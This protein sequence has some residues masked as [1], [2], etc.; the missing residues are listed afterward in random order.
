MS[1]VGQEPSF[2]MINIREILVRFVLLGVN[3]R[4]SETRSICQKQTFESVKYYLF[5]F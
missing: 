3:S 2:S 1:A 4:L 5:S